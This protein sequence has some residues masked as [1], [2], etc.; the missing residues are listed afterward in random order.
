MFKFKIN[1]SYNFFYFPLYQIYQRQ[2]AT[3]INKTT[4]I[5]NNL[6]S[7]KIITISN[8]FQVGENNSLSMYIILFI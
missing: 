7:H 2:R 5:I 8:W 1:L 6:F 3:Q 4:R